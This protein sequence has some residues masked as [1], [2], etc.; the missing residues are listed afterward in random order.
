MQQ[1]QETNVLLSLRNENQHLKDKIMELNSKIEQM[2]QNT[3]RTVTPNYV[4]LLQNQLQ[5]GTMST[6]FKIQTA[7]PLIQLQQDNQS[8]LT[9]LPAQQQH[10]IGSETGI[11]S[12]KTKEENTR[13]KYSNFRILCFPL[14]LAST[15]ECRHSVSPL[16]IH[17]YNLIKYAKQTVSA[18]RVGPRFW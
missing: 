16:H 18:R 11:Q 1:A 2:A 17:T 3:T 4:I 6:P 7:I 9:N 12:R 14:L 10:I 5:L 15:L 13:A 8:L